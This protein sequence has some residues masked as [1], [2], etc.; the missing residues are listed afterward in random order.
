MRKP[1]VHQSVEIHRLVGAVE[2]TD[3]DMYDAD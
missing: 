2:A 1:C 3:P